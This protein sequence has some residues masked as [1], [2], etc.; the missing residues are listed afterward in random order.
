[1]T[2]E[3][4]GKTGGVKYHHI[5]QSFSPEYNI[6]PERAH[7]IGKELAERQFKGFE[8]FVVTHKIKTIYI[9]I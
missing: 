6:T 5:I 9:I 8:V 1:M 3:L 4:Y 7:E 2:K